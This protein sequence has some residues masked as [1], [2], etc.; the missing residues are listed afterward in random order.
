M[1]EDDI[2]CNTLG[3][4]STVI[5]CL[6]LFVLSSGCAPNL[7][8]QEKR[9][10]I[11]FLADWAE[12][13]SPFVEANEQIKGCPSYRDLLPKYLEYAEQA[14]NNRQ[15]LHVVLGYFHLICNSGHAYMD[16]G[17]GSW[18][19]TTDYWGRLYWQYC[20]AGAP[21]RVFNVGQEYF[22]GDDWNSGQAIVPRGSK[23][24]TVNGLSCP[25]YLEFVKKN[26]WIRYLPAE[27]LF[28][29][30]LFE[31]K[32]SE[33]SNGW[34]VE[35]LKPDGQVQKVFVS[36]REWPPG[37]NNS[38]TNRSEDNCVC[39]ELNDRIGYIRIK[40]FLYEHMGEDREEIRQFLANAKG[41][42][43]KLII[44][45]RDNPGGSARYYHKNLIAPLIKETVTYSQVAGLKRRFISDNTPSYIKGLRWRVS[46]FCYETV[47]EEIEP[48][49]GYDG[50]EWIFYRATREI[51]PK[52][53]YDFDGEIYVLVDHRSFSAAEGYAIAVKKTGYAKL[54]GVNTAGGAA[55]YVAPSMITLPNSGMKFVIETDM[56]INPDGS[57]NEIVGTPPDIKLPPADIPSGLTREALL[58]DTWIQK[59]IYD[60]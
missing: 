26:S 58:E 30:R 19:G 41:K 37:L 50:K 13:Y 56:V 39:V 21:F 29:R 47:V 14:R 40:I 38:F 22:V 43:D 27:T 8:V 35:F 7:T 18:W 48:P 54:A 25:A 59:V 55:A 20:I 52:D 16:T 24:L 33:D 32:E 1:K 3:I 2:A 60:L 6:T 9:E 5:S 15:F 28:T 11:Q 31:V 46:I 44:D 45:V 23:I 51:E 36:R 4:T 57:I 10:D 49:T 42:Y 34:N 17:T 53:P 12:H